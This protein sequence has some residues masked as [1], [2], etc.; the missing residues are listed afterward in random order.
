MK[1]YKYWQTTFLDGKSI[2]KYRVGIL[3]L[4]FLLTIAIPLSAQDLQV[5][6]TVPTQGIDNFSVCGE[7]KPISLTIENP[8]IGPI[9]LTTD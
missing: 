6:L 1:F 7:P 5:N 4:L 9:S 3:G 2:K 8:L